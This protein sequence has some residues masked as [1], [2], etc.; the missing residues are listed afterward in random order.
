MIAAPYCTP[1][2][3]GPL[4]ESLLWDKL[5]KGMDHC[6]VSRSALECPALYLSSRP[7]H[8][9]GSWM[10]PWPFVS[11]VHRWSLACHSDSYVK[12]ATRI[13]FLKYRPYLFSAYKKP[14][15]PSRDVVHL[16]HS[17]IT[18]QYM[19]ATGSASLKKGLD[20]G[21]F[22]CSLTGLLALA[23]SWAGLPVLHHPGDRAI[24]TLHY[25]IFARGPS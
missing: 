13:V 25:S 9:A 5:Q 14:L 7:L 18:A 23:L 3:L 6:W 11:L 10:P 24:V 15:I 20:S 4:Q 1:A 17:V 21:C 12:P 2:R 8:G 22:H 16:I 19:H